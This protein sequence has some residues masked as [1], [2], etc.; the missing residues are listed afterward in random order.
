MYFLNFLFISFTL[1]HVTQ[2]WQFSPSATH[3]KPDLTPRKASIK[4][5][6]QEELTKLA[7]AEEDEDDDEEEEPNAENVQVKKQKVA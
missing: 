5:M 4:L 3:Y 6:I 7:E 2:L 1:I